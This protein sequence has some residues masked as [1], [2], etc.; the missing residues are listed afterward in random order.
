MTYNTQPDY[1]LPLS[2]TTPQE[3][4]C[5]SRQGYEA[6]DGGEEVAVGAWV[7]IQAEPSEAAGEA[8]C[9]AEEIQDVHLRERV[10]LAWTSCAAAN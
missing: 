8:G 4:G 9:G 10:L 2:P 1:G 5:H 3:H 7:P 6:G